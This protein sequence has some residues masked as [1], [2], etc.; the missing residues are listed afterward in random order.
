[1][2]SLHETFVAASD[3]LERLYSAKLFTLPL[4]EFLRECKLRGE[5][6]RQLVADLSA[7][8]GQKVDIVVPKVKESRLCAVT[9]LRIIVTEPKGAACARGNLFELRAEVDGCAAPRLLRHC[10]AAGTAPAEPV[11]KRGKAKRVPRYLGKGPVTVYR[12][13]KRA[14]RPTKNKKKE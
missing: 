1:M 11:F 2:S 12:K 3:E 5:R 4:K 14:G 9:L 10:Y 6:T 8:T 7:F 13:K